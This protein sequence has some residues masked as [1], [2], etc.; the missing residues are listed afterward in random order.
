MKKAFTLAETVIVLA[1]IGFLAIILL[2]ALQNLQPDKEKTMFKKAYQITERTVG[3]LVNDESI[4]PYDPENIGF[5]N[6]EKADVEGTTSYWEGEQKFCQFF[7]R[8]LNTYA[9][10]VWDDA[11]KQCKFQTTDGISWLVPSVFV[12]P[13]SP[14]VRITVDVNGSEE[15]GGKGPNTKDDVDNRDVYEIIV[16]FDGRV[17]VDGEREIE[18]LKSHDAT[19][20]YKSSTETQNSV[21]EEELPQEES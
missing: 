15:D 9:D 7:A 17:R 11:N 19:K 4:Y 10:A 12:N 3:E 5:Y 13:T 21:S 20:K 16:E 14:N 6:D 8:K 18:Y 2:R 1:V